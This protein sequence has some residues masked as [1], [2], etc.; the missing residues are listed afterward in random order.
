MRLRNRSA[1]LLTAPQHPIRELITS[2]Q[3]HQRQTLA[4]WQTLGK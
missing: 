2:T 3:C 4:Q 1:Q